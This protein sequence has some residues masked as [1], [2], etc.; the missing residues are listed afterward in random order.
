M[1][2]INKKELLTWLY[3]K[4]NTLS[5]A[6]ES[7]F[8]VLEKNE[9]ASFGCQMAALVCVKSAIKYAELNMP[10]IENVISSLSA[11]EMTEKEKSF[12]KSGMAL[13]ESIAKTI[14]MYKSL[15]ITI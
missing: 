2:E 7:A 10:E 11:A 9:S 15:N 14:E 5:S 8:K 13:K 1:T 3:V 12:F 6:I 4:L